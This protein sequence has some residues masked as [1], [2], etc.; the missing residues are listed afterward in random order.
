MSGLVVEF[1]GLPGSGKTSLAECTREAIVAHG[2]VCSIA[3][4]EVSAAA[5]KS[6]R[7]VRRSKAAAREGVRHPSASISAARLIGSTGNAATRDL[8]AGL[9]QWLTIRDIILRAHRT[10][11]VHLVEEG[12]VQSLW[13]IALRAQHDPARDLW[14]RLG[15]DSRPDLILVLETTSTTAAARLESRESRH[16]RTQR[17]PTESRIGELEHGRTLFE[18]QLAACPVPVLRIAVDDAGSPIE[19]GQAVAALILRSCTRCA[20]PGRSR[21]RTNRPSGS[22]YP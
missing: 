13:T 11:G 7:I 14:R 17:L 20:G 15:P 4:A 16:S 8:L 21:A 1:C 3:D 9:A 10:P 6:A 22:R 18:R 19:L 5:T 2:I 12:I